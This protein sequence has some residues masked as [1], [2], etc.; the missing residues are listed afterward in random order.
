MV[1]PRFTYLLPT[2]DSINGYIFPSDR[3]QLPITVSYYLE[4]FCVDS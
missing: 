1:L 4:F 2:R 3:L